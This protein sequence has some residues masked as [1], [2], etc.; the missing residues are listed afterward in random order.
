MLL[1]GSVT[2]FG[3]VLIMMRGLHKIGPDKQTF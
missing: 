3:A 1:L 2:P